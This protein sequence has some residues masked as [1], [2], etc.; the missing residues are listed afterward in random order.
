MNFTTNIYIFIYWSLNVTLSEPNL[1]TNSA[2][3]DCE[4][5]YKF[6]S[7]C[8]LHVSYS[9]RP[10]WTCCCHPLLIQKNYNYCQ[11]DFVSNVYFRSIIRQFV[12]MAQHKK[13]DRQTHTHNGTTIDIITAQPIHVI[14]QRRKHSSTK[15]CLRRT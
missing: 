11:L 9:E 6:L 8:S 7:V 13:T 4:I 14:W 3:C 2:I 12:W 5:H 15:H 10:S 1:K